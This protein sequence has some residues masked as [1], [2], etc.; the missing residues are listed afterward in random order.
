M[1]VRILPERVV[2]VKSLL[3]VFVEAHATKDILAGHSGEGKT[4]R[5]HY[6][7]FLSLEEPYS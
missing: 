1:A 3:E 2:M 5:T 4:H 7:I 6:C